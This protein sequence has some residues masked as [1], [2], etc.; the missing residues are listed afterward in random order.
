MSSED[1][2]PPS[3]GKEEMSSLTT[4]DTSVEIL[5][6]SKEGKRTSLIDHFPDTNDPTLSNTNDE[7]LNHLHGVSLALMLV[8]LSAAVFCVALDMTIIATA[9]PR[10]S[11]DFHALQDIGWYG[12]AY[13]L[14]QCC[15]LNL[16]KISIYIPLLTTNASTRPS[17]RQNL[18][19]LQPQMGIHVV[20]ILLRSRL[21]AMWRRA[22]F[23]GLDHWCMLP[24]PPTSASLISRLASHRRSRWGRSL[25]WGY[26]H[27]C[28]YCA[29]AQETFVSGRFWGH[30]WSCVCRG[31]VDW[32]GL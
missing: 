27:C 13:L 3:L 17:L 7:S 5:P 19:T 32:W 14:T 25:L 21:C 12:S 31:A 11:D 1:R 23:R 15:K 2:V 10:I 4:P 29:N 24:L 30:V 20:I 9:I 26:G 28:A 22:C 8:A 6:E 18:R 16:L